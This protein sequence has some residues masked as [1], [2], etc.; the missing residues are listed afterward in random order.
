MEEPLFFTVTSS[1]DPESP[2]HFQLS[3]ADDP[4]KVGRNKK[5]GIVVNQPGV[6]WVH[7]EIKLSQGADGLCLRD[8]STN[9]VG[10]RRRGAGLQ[11][12]EKEVD[13]DLPS[14][15]VVVLPFRVR[16]APGQ[17]EA[18]LQTSLT[19]SIDGEDSLS[20][21]S[22]LTESEDPDAA[23]DVETFNPQDA[24]ENGKGL[25]AP[26]GKRKK[27][28]KDKPA[29]DK[30][31]KVKHEFSAGQFVRVVGL[32]AKGELNGKVG[33]LVEWDKAK[34]YWKVRMEDGSGK[35][36][37][38]ANLEPHVVPPPAPAGSSK[39]ASTVPPPP[40]D[41]PAP[42][43][44]GQEVPP[45]PPAMEEDAAKV[46]PLP[47]AP[48]AHVK[49][50]APRPPPGTLPG[51]P[52]ALPGAPLSLTMPLPGLP[53]TVPTMMPMAGLMGSMVPVMPPGLPLIGMPPAAVPLAIP[54]PV[55]P[56]R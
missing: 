42:K 45:P 14:G 9:G 5:S 40:P 39:A 54:P 48:A 52:T 50:A 18:S 12:V 47:P 53:L 56:K 10:I 46:L 35:A 36:F 32:K 41:E 26:K 25:E 13:T 21:S 28:G 7:L 38:S 31:R 4:L 11:K 34:G 3:K 30:K 19:F 37:R 55:L 49:K 24:P 15:T 16:P 1:E 20:P 29:K 43:E 8:V 23:A 33:L 17:T 2:L 27:D 22:E 6:S 44:Q 51:A